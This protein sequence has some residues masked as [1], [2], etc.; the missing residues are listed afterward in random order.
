M[1]VGTA[2]A[3]PGA[4]VRPST[5]ASL[6]TPQ[7]ETTIEPG[8]VEKIATRAAAETDGVAEVVPGGAG[9]GRILPGASH[10]KEPTS[11]SADVHRDTTTVDLTVHVRYP[12]PA[13]TVA[14]RVRQNVIARVHQLTGLTVDEVNVT[15]PQLVVGG[16]RPRPRV[17]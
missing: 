4:P 1:S 9:L 5:P 6:H 15:V 11:A 13:M 7:G 17:Q 2:S 8:V 3:G 12:E 10:D 14:E 16:R